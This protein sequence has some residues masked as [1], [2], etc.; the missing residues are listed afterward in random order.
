MTTF[1]DPFMTVTMTEMYASV[2]I[3]RHS[4]QNLMTMTVGVNVND[5]APW[6][7]GVSRS[8]RDSK[9]QCGGLKNSFNN[10]IKGARRTRVSPR[11]P[12]FYKVNDENIFDHCLIKQQFGK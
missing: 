5:A 8:T 9:L 12:L 6:S 7:T 3:V 10:A 2:I 1:N 11:L 4:I